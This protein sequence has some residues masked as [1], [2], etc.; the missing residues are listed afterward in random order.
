MTSC[1]GRVIHL[2]GLLVVLFLMVVFFHF[3]ARSSFNQQSLDRPEVS[4]Y[5]QAYDSLCVVALH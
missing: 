4:F 3:F 5:D 1:S 2:A